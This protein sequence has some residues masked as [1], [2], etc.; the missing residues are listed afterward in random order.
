[1]CIHLNQL[2]K[3]LKFKDIYFLRIETVLKCWQLEIFSV[4]LHD[5]LNIN[6]NKYQYVRSNS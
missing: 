2:L 5:F 1:M 6:F 4:I 3:Q